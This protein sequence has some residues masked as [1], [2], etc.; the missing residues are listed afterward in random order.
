MINVACVKNALFPSGLCKWILYNMKVTMQSEHIIDYPLTAKCE[1]SNFE[2][3]FVTLKVPITMFSCISLV[4]WRAIVLLNNQQSTHLG[5]YMSHCLVTTNKNV[6]VV[7]VV[8]YTTHCKAA[9][10]SYFCLI[11][12]RCHQEC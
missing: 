11:F 4:K 9:F 3:F 12:S 2:S 1:A 6:V 8:S 5:C 7:T 10:Q